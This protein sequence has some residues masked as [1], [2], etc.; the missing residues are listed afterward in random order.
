MIQYINNYKGDVISVDCKGTD[1]KNKAGF[2]ILVLVLQNELFV[3]NF[4]LVDIS[5]L[6]EL[7]ILTNNKVGKLFYDCRQDIYA[8]SNHIQKLDYVQDLSVFHNRFLKLESCAGIVKV[9]KFWKIYEPCEI[10]ISG[11]TI[12]VDIEKRKKNKTKI[13]KRWT[14]KKSVG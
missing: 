14:I 12:F 4:K 8:I 7:K 6:L 3:F 1:L 5:I 13:G 10:E 11:K 2:N 9:A